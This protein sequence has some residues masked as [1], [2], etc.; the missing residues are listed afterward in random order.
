MFLHDSY[1][2]VPTRVKCYTIKSQSEKL[3]CSN[4]LLQAM[5]L[6]DVMS[7]VYAEENATKIEVDHKKQPALNY[8][9]I[10]KTIKKCKSENCICEAY[11][12]HA[13]EDFNPSPYLN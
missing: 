6:F 11:K 7:E 12:K 2:D 3:I 4:E 13:N 1:G 10:S 8:Y 9:L 5:E